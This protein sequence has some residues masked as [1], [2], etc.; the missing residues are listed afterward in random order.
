MT[1]FL[2]IIGSMFVGDVLWLIWSWRKLRVVKGGRAW[3][4]LMA[5]FV[6]SQIGGMAWLLMYRMGK[7]PGPP[8]GILGASIYIWH[9]LVLPLTAG[10]LLIALIVR[11]LVAI[12]RCIG[13]AFEKAHPPLAI[14]FDS[15]TDVAPVQTVGPSRRQVLVGAACAIPPLIALGA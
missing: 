4:M 11:A 12:V 1:F 7:V 15:V 2:S 9:I 3:Q 5:G 13:C 10:V 14:T 6:V 8:P